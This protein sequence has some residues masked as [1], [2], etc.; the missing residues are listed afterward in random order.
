MDAIVAATLRTYLSVA[1]TGARTGTRTGT[2]TRT[3]GYSSLP[4]KACSWIHRGYLSRSTRRVFLCRRRTSG[5]FTG[6]VNTKPYEREREVDESL[7]AYE[8]QTSQQSSRVRTLLRV[9]F[10]R[11]V[12]GSASGTYRRLETTKS[13]T[14]S[15]SGL[16]RTNPFPS[17]S[18][19]FQPSF[20]FFS[21]SADVPFDPRESSR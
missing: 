17:D 10:H 5:A 19:S 15:L 13:T 14:R 9:R 3:R 11:S 12:S 16:D 7:C 20:V 6:I 2:G 8:S 18:S 4:V 1:I 21:T